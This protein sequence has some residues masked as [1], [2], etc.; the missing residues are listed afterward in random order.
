[1]AKECASH[2]AC[3]ATRPRVHEESENI[4]QMTFPASLANI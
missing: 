2:Q 1:M 4:G 3:D